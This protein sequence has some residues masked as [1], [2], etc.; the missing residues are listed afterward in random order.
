M[1][2]TIARSVG[3]L[4]ANGLAARP[5]GEGAHFT[6][7]GGTNRKK[8]RKREQ[9]KE[10]R[11]GSNT[12]E[13]SRPMRA[14]QRTQQREKRVQAGRAGGHTKRR[15]VWCAWRVRDDIRLKRIA[16]M[17]H[18]RGAGGTCAAGAE[19]W[20][21]RAAAILQARREQISGYRAPKPSRPQLSFR[22]A[23]ATVVSV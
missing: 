18:E 7:S 16:R 11:Q 23:G 22:D 13:R 3:S 6:G 9:G 12:S 21:R 5:R 14:Q 15:A 17:L 19:A 2:G 10:A 1:E 20:Q 8:W 4:R